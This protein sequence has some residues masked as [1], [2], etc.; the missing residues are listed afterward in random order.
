MEGNDPLKIPLARQPIQAAPVR[1][2][3]IEVAQTVGGSSGV[4]HDGTKPALPFEQRKVPLVRAVMV[5]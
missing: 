4:R 5:A 3:V 1:F 2:D